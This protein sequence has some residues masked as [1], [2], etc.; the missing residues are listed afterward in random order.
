MVPVWKIQAGRSLATVS[1]LMRSSGEAWLLLGPPP[2]DGQSSAAPG[3]PQPPPRAPQRPPPDDI[4]GVSQ[5][6]DATAAEACRDLLATEAIF[7]GGSTGSV[8]TAVRRLVSDLEPPVRVVA[9]FPDRG[10]RY[11][12]TGVF[13]A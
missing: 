4:P 5:A 9:I 12:S 2:K 8:V 7:A 1:R 3:G 11:L 10:D 13:P 6:D